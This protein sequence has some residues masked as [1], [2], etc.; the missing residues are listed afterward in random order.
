MPISD[1]DLYA[2]TCSTNDSWVDPLLLSDFVFTTKPN[3]TGQELNKSMCT[4]NPDEK[5]VFY[6]ARLQVL[7]TLCLG[8]HKLSSSHVQCVSIPCL[9]AHGIC[10]RESYKHVVGGLLMDSSFEHLNA[11]AS[12]HGEG[13]ECQNCE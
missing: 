5:E 11:A 8:P 12:L 13:F 10:S 9:S 6:N 1:G 3:Y 7:E 4:M 2:G